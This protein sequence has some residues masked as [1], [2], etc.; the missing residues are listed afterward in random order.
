[1]FVKGKRLGCQ[2]DG[3]EDLQEGLKI[4]I[5]EIGINNIK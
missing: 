2:W 3:W 4:Q 1:M 5:Y